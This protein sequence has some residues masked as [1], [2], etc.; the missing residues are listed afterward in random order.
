MTVEGAEALC[1]RLDACA[2]RL[3]Q[4]RPVPSAELEQLARAVLSLAEAVSDEERNRL[5]GR[6][7]AVT[8][9]LGARR[10]V[11]GAQLSQMR[12]GRRVV[13][14]YHEHGGR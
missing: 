13:R 6:L 8:S 11:I 3:D 2:W 12:Q 14:R 4:G 1:V 10:D 5:L 9:A 7:A